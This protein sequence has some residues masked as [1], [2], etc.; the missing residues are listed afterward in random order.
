MKIG[1]YKMFL[2]ILLIL[3]FPQSLHA[4]SLALDQFRHV[5]FKNIGPT[6]YTQ[7]GSGLKAEV[8]GSSSF[9]LS[10]FNRT[11]IVKSLKWSWKFTGDYKVNSAEVLTTKKGDDAILRVGL[12]KEGSAPMVPFFAPSWVKAIREHMKLPGDELT[13]F[14]AGGPAKPGAKWNSSYSD[15][16][17]LIQVESVLQEDGWMQVSYDL[18]EPIKAVGLWIM[19]D[20]DNSGSKF[21]VWLKNLVIVE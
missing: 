14:V 11:R 13:Y 6:S 3:P 8:N 10:A 18:G 15:S 17:H 2:M 4:E 1:S 7:D 21:T 9:L 5:T 16:M 20:G 19:S 12:I